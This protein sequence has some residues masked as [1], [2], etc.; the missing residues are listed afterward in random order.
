MKIDL[1]KELAAYRAPRGRFE[2]VDVPAQQYLMIDGHGDPNTVSEYR[3]AVSAL[4]GAAFALKFHS[5]R[6][7][8]RDYV[9]MPLEGLWWSDDLSAFTSAREKSQWDWTMMILVPDWTLPDHLESARRAVAEK[10]A[11]P[12]LGLLRLETL[13]EGRCVQTLHVGPYDAEGPVLE[14]MHHEFLPGAGLR[15]RGKHHE[16]YLA[17]ARRTAPERLRTI[18]RQPVETS[19]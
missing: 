14:R 18:L 9:V 2:V 5:K 19:G 13:T 15:P 7:L 10:G 8:D 11:A 17:D 12:A 16:I 3:D 1:K 6:V 4:Y